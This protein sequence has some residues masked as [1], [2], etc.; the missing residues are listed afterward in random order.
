MCFHLHRYSISFSTGV[1]LGLALQPGTAFFVVYFDK[2]LVVANGLNSA[3]SAVGFLT[4]P[5]LM[6]RMISHYG[7][8]GALQITSAIMANI[9][10]CGVLLRSPPGEPKS[11]KLQQ[12][13][14]GNATQKNT[15]TCGGFFKE[16]GKGFDISL[17][18]NLRFILQGVGNGFL[19]GANNT[20]IIYLIP[21]AFSV[22][23]PDIKASYL[24]LAFG[25]S[26][27]ITRLCPVGWV[28]DRKI[29]SA[30]T[31]GGLAFFNSGVNIV[32]ASFVT[33]FTVLVAVAVVFGVT[34]GIGSFLRMV[35]VINVCGSRQKALGAIGW[36]LL[37]EG[38]GSFS[39]ILLMGK[40]REPN[41]AATFASQPVIGHSLSCFF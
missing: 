11:G 5:P 41:S 38:V 22:G 13:Q 28:V 25:I 29:I 34:F 10:V 40:E 16:V 33:S 37:F 36:T 2:W 30:S 26:G 6:E 18:R 14:D 32:I 7:W 3:A 19:Y 20:A 17:F 35:V 27:L 12:K 24:M 31:L 1:G 9:C 39:C 4:L 23:I 15:D 21:H 8:R